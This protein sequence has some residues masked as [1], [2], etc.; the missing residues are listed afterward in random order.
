[1]LKHVCDINHT[2]R[3][4]DD[5]Q[6][7]APMDPLMLKILKCSTAVENAFDARLGDA[8][9]SELENLE[10]MEKKLGRIKLGDIAVTKVEDARRGREAGE[11]ASWQYACR[12]PTM[13]HEFSRIYRALDQNQTLKMTRWSH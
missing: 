11:R 7:S 5:V 10:S 1:M 3:L 2:N 8:G 9:F 4:R 12:C 13:E 6:A